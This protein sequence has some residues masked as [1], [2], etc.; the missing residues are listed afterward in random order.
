MFVCIRTMNKKYR[1]CRVFPDSPVSHLFG[2]GYRK[3]KKPI[4]VRAILVEI[5]RGRWNIGGGREEGV[6]EKKNRISNNSS[7]KHQITTTRFPFRG[8]KKTKKKKEIAARVT[9][10]SVGFRS[11]FGD[12]LC[13]LKRLIFRVVTVK[14][15][16]HNKLLF[17]RF[18]FFHPVY[19]GN[20][21][22]FFLLIY[23]YI[24]VYYIG[25]PPARCMVKHEGRMFF[26]FFFSF[27]NSFSYTLYHLLL[28]SRLL[29]LLLLLLFR[30]YSGE[31]AGGDCGMANWL[32]FCRSASVRPRAFSD[33]PYVPFVPFVPARRPI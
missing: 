13:I 2:H 11:R 23:I 24:F 14:T 10:N 21:I 25:K 6:G 5:D 17:F 20:A 26:F 29:L 33:D 1:F 16:D 30:K 28:Y 3:K 8:K 12:L 7:E 27:L 32:E 15:A 19:R 31:L 9:M 22:V 4:K 18:F